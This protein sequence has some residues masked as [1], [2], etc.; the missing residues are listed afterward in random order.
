MSAIFTAE[1]IHDT[2]DHNLEFSSRLNL[3]GRF[4]R[5]L[6]HKEGVR[7]ARNAPVNTP[8]S[9]GPDIAA[10]P[11]MLV[12]IDIYSGL[13]LSGTSLGPMVRLPE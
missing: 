10:T 4:V 12:T 13:C 8:P 11:Y 2:I 9:K 7:L 6:A 1:T 5:H 3:M